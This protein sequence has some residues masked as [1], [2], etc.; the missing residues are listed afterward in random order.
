MKRLYLIVVLIVLAF[1]AT[2]VLAQQ[3]GDSDGDGVPDSRDNCPNTAGSVDNNGC[4]VIVIAPQQPV[5]SDGDGLPDSED[6]CPR[7]SGPRSNGGCPLTVIVTPSV[8]DADGDGVA[9]PNDA[10]PTVAGVPQNNGCPGASPTPSGIDDLSP[11]PVQITVTP[12]PFSP[13]N[14]PAD[15]C[16]VTPISSANVNVRET[17]DAGASILGALMAGSVY[18]ADGILTSDGGIWFALTNYAG[19]SG[20]TGYSS[21][22]V[23]LAT[24]GCPSIDVPTDGGLIINRVLDT[25]DAGVM[26]MQCFPQQGTSLL[27]SCWCDSNDSDCVDQLVSMCW[28]GDAY[29]D[30][31][32]DMT[33]CWWVHDLDVGLTDLPDEDVPT[34]VILQ[35]VY[36]TTS[37]HDCNNNGI[38]DRDEFWPPDCIGQLTSEGGDS[39]P[40]SGVYFDYAINALSICVPG[41]IFQVFPSRPDDPICINPIDDLLGTGRPT[42]GSILVG[43]IPDDD[44]SPLVLPVPVW[45]E[46]L[47][48]HCYPQNWW[49]SVDDDGNVSGG[50][51]RDD[52]ED[53]SDNAEPQIGMQIREVEPGIPTGPQAYFPGRNVEESDTTP[54]GL[55]EPND[56]F[57]TWLEDENGDVIPGSVD[58]ECVPPDFWD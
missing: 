53:A 28:G 21:R 52:D 9:D 32:P 22:S 26:E 4:P 42:D 2:S 36:G 37:D 49:S 43:I 40:D 1:G 11:N 14:L 5:D 55:C 7:S 39:S 6:Q 23:L 24:S 15:G 44:P 54:E 35:F 18:G 45:E 19:S 48:T 46:F 57:F 25:S 38:D 56:P 41:Q 3:R 34:V 29:I 20:T 12:P 27:E 50:C 17:P 13:P 8:A 16:F 51:W 33:A 30:A 58:L 47:T 31:G 10:C